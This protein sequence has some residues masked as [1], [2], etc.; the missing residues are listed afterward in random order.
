M[1]P[2]E[3]IDH[4]NEVQRLQRLVV[5]AGNH[6]WRKLNP[7]DLSGSWDIQMDRL[8][9]VLT[10]AQVA[11]AE[12]GAS[13]GAL[14]LAAQGSYAAPE[15]F[16]NAEAFGGWSSDG[17]TLRGL[18]E[19]PIPHVKTLIGQGVNP[20]VAMKQGG[21][22][23]NLLTRT[24]V[25]DAARTAAGVDTAARPQVKYIRMLNPPSCKRCSV[26]AG[27]QFRW[28]QGFLRHPGCDCIHIPTT[29]VD[30]A[31]SEGLMHDPYEYFN[32]LSE[33]EQ[34]TTYGIADSKA[35]RDGADIFQV[36]NAQRGVNA[37]GMKTTEGT[38]A[39]SAYGKRIRLTPE[40]I[41]KL[42]GDNR[43]AALKDLEKYGY[44]LPGGQN[45]LGSIRG[46]REGFGQLG[47]GGAWEAARK[48]VFD[49][50]INGRDPKVRHTMTAA[51]RRLFDANDR[52]EQVQKGLNPFDNPALAKREGRPMAPLT[53]QVAAMV[54]KD[55]RRWL[56]TGGQ[57]F[58]S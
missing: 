10:S 56:S 23:L 24:Q 51:E 48:R 11:A 21:N 25:S 26:L 37:A 47:H 30:T 45:P 14:T 46:Q 43:A 1:I 5:L 6:A 7:N 34:N 36:V 54:E 38:T 44:I 57:V 58:Q 52:W 50:R 40:A 4:Y 12:S 19:A 3:A 35:I 42:N 9:A 39:R 13:Y 2:E 20:R 16:V 32:S 53:P 28:N 22:F 55:Y 15:A 33:A 41:Y 18:L 49:A 17:R 27:K 8:I 29:N 31:K